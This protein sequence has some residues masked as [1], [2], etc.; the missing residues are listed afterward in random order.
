MSAREAAIKAVQEHPSTTFM[1]PCESLADAVL[2]AA[3]PHI[4]AEVLREV[5]EKIRSEKFTE[6]PVDA[7]KMLINSV[8]ETVARKIDPY[9]KGE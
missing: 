7:D 9:V 8:L 4:E 5:A 1:A 2:K 3:T 6:L